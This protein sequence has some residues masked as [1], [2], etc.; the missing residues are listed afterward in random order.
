[1]PAFGK[2]SAKYFLIKIVQT[3]ID[4]FSKTLQILQEA[5]VTSAMYRYLQ[6][7]FCK[8]K[9]VPFYNFYTPIDF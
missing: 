1:M 8:S 9:G 4:L 5:F 3:M 2:S 7:R 6:T